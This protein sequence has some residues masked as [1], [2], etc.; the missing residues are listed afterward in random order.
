MSVSMRVTPD[1]GVSA[2]ATSFV[3]PAGEAFHG[4]GGRHTRVDQRGRTLTGWIQAQNVSAGQL[5]PGVDQIPGTGDEEYLF[6]NWPSAASAT[7][8]PTSPSPAVCHPSFPTC[9]IAPSGAP[10]GTPRNRRL[11]RLRLRRRHRGAVHPMAPSRS[12]DTL[13]SCAQLVLDGSEDAL[14]LRTHRT[15]AFPPVLPAPRSKRCPT[16]VD[17]SASRSEPESRR[18]D[19]CGSSS[20]VNRAFTASPT[21]GCSDPTSSSHPCS[22]NE[23]APALSCCHAA[24]GGTYLPEKQW[25]ADDPSE[26]RQTSEP[27]PTSPG[28]SKHPSSPRRRA[29]ARF[30]DVAARPSTLPPSSVLGPPSGAGRS[31]LGPWP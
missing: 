21:N 13:L 4:F 12:P 23:T 15:G 20:P 1:L 29:D 5:Q 31:R 8:P 16:Y 30:L 11:L 6:P 22:E 10:G 25:P 17:S 28:A 3:S 27:S 18:P 14:G 24:A 7:R 9:S 19:R 2:V 26:S